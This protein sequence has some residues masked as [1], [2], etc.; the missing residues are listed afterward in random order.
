MQIAEAGEDVIVTSRGRPKVKIVRADDTESES[1][2]RQKAFDEMTRRLNSQTA[3]N[4]PR[5][6]RGGMYD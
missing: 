6:T 3:Q 1:E 2:Q 5:A 4:L